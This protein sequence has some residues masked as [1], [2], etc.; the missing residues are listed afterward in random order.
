MV[1]ITSHFGSE[2]ENINEQFADNP[3]TDPKHDRLGYAAFARHLAD[4]ICKMN[5]PEGFV[6][7]IYGPW[8][9]GKS[10]LLNFL[11]HYLK[12]KPENEQPIIV[13]FN[14][15]LFTG[16]EAITRRFVNQLQISLSQLK[17]VP[18]GFRKRIA[19]FVKAVSEIPVPYAQAGKAVVK[20]FDNKEKDISEL[21]EDL[22]ET[23]ED[24]HPR[25]V[26]AIDE[27]DRLNSDD[28]MQLFRLLKAIPN[29]D[30]VVYVLA[31][32]QE[33]IH[34]IISETQNIPGDVYLEK[35]IQ[36]T[37]KL[38][39]PDKT[40]LRRLLFEKLN[41]IFAD[42]PKQIFDTT[43][44]SNI[45]SQG[46][47]YFINTPRDIVR[48][49]NMLTVTYP[50][51]QGEVNPADIVAIESL[52]VF[53]PEI[54]DIIHKNPQFFAGYI[55]TQDSSIPT[56][57]ELKYFHNS[58]LAQIKDEDKQPI[59]RLLMRLFPKLEAVYCKT[60]YDAKHESIW[61]K[62]LRICSLETFA[63]YFRLTLTEG[64][65]SDIEMK[66]VLTLACDPKAFGDKLIEL[67]N[68]QHPDG[69]TQIRAFLEQLE[70]YTETAIPLNCIATIVQ[71][72]FD[73]G[74]HLL[75]S[76]DQPDGIFDLGTDIRVERIIAQLLHR[77]HEQERFE[78][79]KHAMSNSNAVSTIVSEITTLIQEQGKYRMEDCSS[80]GEWFLSREHLKELEKI[81]L[82]R[83]QA[84][85]QH[86]SLLDVAK[87]LEKLYFWQ[88]LTEEKVKQSIQKVID[89]NNEEL[90]SSTNNS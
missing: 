77:I 84:V 48:L 14:P 60:Y 56:V 37:F 9:F 2:T 54:Y 59:K 44:W 85:M 11:V 86:S 39:L 22:E 81:A 19:D 43:H 13:P 50:V 52:R 55:N 28:I 79:L 40:L 24:K 5:F 23:L 34:K 63:N 51:V 21:K 41:I 3:L 4:S 36:A 67:A 49:T 72:F 65:F 57:D 82:Q 62:Y 10:T 6:I 74:D 88:S 7:A 76:E 90:G 32:N 17:A 66:A 31:F 64:K 38:P 8:G 45:Y 18:Q 29:F 35:I 83:L 33:V 42:T 78:T 12:D 30:N 70:D 68:Q 26:V 53:R 69:I 73:V 89:I 20:L 1:E 75:R 58:W 47:D 61:R 46:L 25:I 80:P 15:W 87:L 71:A 16:D 27:I